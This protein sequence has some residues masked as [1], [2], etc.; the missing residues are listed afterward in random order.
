M[1]IDRLAFETSVTWTP[2]VVPGPPIPPVRFQMIQLSM[3]PKS[4]SPASAFSRAPRT[5][6]RSQRS[7]GPEK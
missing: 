2:G 4:R 7:L 1:S 3:V 5:L 6:S